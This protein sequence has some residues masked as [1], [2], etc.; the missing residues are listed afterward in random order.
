MLQVYQ[1]V[2]VTIVLFGVQQQHTLAWDWKEEAPDL[3]GIGNPNKW[4][5]TEEPVHSD[6]AAVPAGTGALIHQCTQPVSSK[7]ASG[8]VPT[9]GTVD[10]PACAEFQMLELEHMASLTMSPRKLALDQCPPSSSGELQQPRSVFENGAVAV[11]D[12]TDRSPAS[13]EVQLQSKMQSLTI[14]PRKRSLEQYEP[15]TAA[16]PNIQP[17]I[18]EPNSRELP[19]QAAADSTA[20]VEQPL[21]RVEPL[22]VSFNEG[23]SDSAQPIS[24]SRFED[25]DS[26]TG[27]GTVQTD[28]RC[29]AGDQH[30]VKSAGVKRSPSAECDPFQEVEQLVHVFETGDPLAETEKYACIESPSGGEDGLDK[31]VCFCFPAL[32]YLPR[33]DVCI[34]MVLL[35][36]K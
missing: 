31:R 29:S 27:T 9:E 23:V 18:E 2:C 10:S 16:V 11:S 1:A 20:C 22:P 21:I 4:E 8:Y 13:T 30:G 35:S 33:I 26:V 6:F 15:S 17:I 36:L 24:A 28:A 25:A 34:A 5:D 19:E 7:T 12:P 14:S 3:D 32:I